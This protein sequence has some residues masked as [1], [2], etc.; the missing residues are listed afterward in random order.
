MCRFPLLQRYARNLVG[1]YDPHIRA[2]I[3]HECL[4]WTHDLRDL[5]DPELLATAAPSRLGFL[6]RG[7]YLLQQVYGFTWCPSDN[8]KL[9]HECVHGSCSA[10][11]LARFPNYLHFLGELA[12]QVYMARYQT[13]LLL[14]KLMPPRKDSPGVGVDPYGDA[15]LNAMNPMLKAECCPRC[16]GYD[17]MTWQE[18]KYTGCSCMNIINAYMIPTSPDRLWWL[19]D[20]TAE[21][22]GPQ[23][24]WSAL[25]C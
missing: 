12:W 21:C 14:D 19:A 15:V 22:T 4:A 1:I 5:P 13:G 9:C 3:F 8:T 23:E 11:M 2:A 18:R 24:E 7:E 6:P 20:P 17:A 16:R 10:G 25:L